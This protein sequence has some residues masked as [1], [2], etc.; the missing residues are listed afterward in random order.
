M[1]MCD[2]VV[3]TGSLTKEIELSQRLL[4]LFITYQIPSDMLTYIGDEKE[5]NKH[6]INTVKQYVQQMYDM[7]GNKYIYIY[8]YTYL[9]STTLFNFSPC[10][11]C[12]VHCTLCNLHFTQHTYIYSIFDVRCSM[13]D[14]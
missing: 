11:L 4:E 1:Y 3:I 5:S 9:H 14:V 13:F 10:V 7:I 6:K 8:T 2:V 12:T